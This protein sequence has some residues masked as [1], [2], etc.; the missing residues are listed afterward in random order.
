MLS[1]LPSVVNLACRKLWLMGLSY[2]INFQPQPLLALWCYVNYWKRTMKSGMAQSRGVAKNN[3]QDPGSEMRLSSRMIQKHLIQKY[4]I[5]LTKPQIWGVLGIRQF[6]FILNK[7]SVL[8]LS[9]VNGSISVVL[10]KITGH[11]SSVLGRTLNL[12][13][14]SSADC[15]P[16]LTALR[17]VGASSKTSWSHCTELGFTSTLFL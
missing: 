8:P 5:W 3:S 15:L 14:L 2:S 6:W 9:F 16:G 17:A 10:K 1:A 13:A 7:C 4:L 11:F 12:K